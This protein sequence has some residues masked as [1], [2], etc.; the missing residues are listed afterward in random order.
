MKVAGIAG[1]EAETLARD[2]TAAHRERG[3]VARIR[4]EG[5]SKR[6]DASADG[7][8]AVVEA[9]A[10]TDYVLSDDHV[11]ATGPPRSLDE[12][13]DEL[14]PRHDYAVVTGH[15]EARIPHVVVGDPHLDG[16]DVA[17]VDGDDP[18]VE[19]AVEAI[20]GVEPHVTL[21]SLVTRAKAS[22]A[23]D[24]AGA[25]ATFTGRVRE[26]DE[27]DDAPTTHL[28]FETYAGVAD[29]RLAAIREELEA[30]DGVFEVV[31]HHRT[32]VVEAGE[33]IV[34]VVVL[35]GHR[36]EAFATVSD[37][38]DRLKAEVPI[39][40]KEVTLDGEFWAHERE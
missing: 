22:P 21:E 3:P 18:D 40:T 30:R 4:Q 1:T 8:V 35:A 34:F 2:V 13:V 16:E 24:R 7:G 36:E 10:D 33:D 20:E 14:A 12:V 27:R 32:G 38:I 5:A 15:P 17:R 11:R 6:E 31:M 23:A 25:I 29:E 37:G 39:F 19:A 28:E 26:R 9:G